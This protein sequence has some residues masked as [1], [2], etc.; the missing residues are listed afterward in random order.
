MSPGNRVHDTD[1]LPSLGQ[2]GKVESDRYQTD[3]YFGEQS[4][5]SANLIP[6]LLGLKFWHRNFTFQKRIERN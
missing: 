1:V 4:V 6:A 5:L 2:T 3:R